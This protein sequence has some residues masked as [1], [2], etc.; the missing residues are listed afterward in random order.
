[1]NEQVHADCLDLCEWVVKDWYAQNCGE[2]GIVDIL[3]R[4]GYALTE[5]CYYNIVMSENDD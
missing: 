1:M 4:Y 2:D 5:D 3:K